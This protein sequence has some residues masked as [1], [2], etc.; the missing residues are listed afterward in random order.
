[1][2]RSIG[3]CKALFNSNNE[4]DPHWVTPIVTEEELNIAYNNNRFYRV[5]GR[6][7]SYDS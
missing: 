1:M 2:K 4:Q 7:F 3:S 5:C 6:G